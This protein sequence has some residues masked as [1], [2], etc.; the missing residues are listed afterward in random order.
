M[1]ESDKVRVSVHCIVYGHARS[2]NYM[3]KNTVLILPSAV[4]RGNK[5]RIKSL[6]VFAC[7]CVN[8]ISSYVA[9]LSVTFRHK[10]QYF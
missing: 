2:E 1:A 3:L 9:T 6:L 7:L 5:S 8:C 4:T 10:I